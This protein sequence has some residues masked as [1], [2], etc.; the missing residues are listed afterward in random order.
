MG[1]LTLPG[2]AGPSTDLYSP[3]AF[4]DRAS[5]FPLPVGTVLLYISSSYKK[6]NNYPAN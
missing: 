1:Q 6:E 2:L 4:P 5:S 3:A